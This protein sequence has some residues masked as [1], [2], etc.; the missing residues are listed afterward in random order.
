MSRATETEAA[1]A[2]IWL[3]QIPQTRE[4]LMLLTDAAEQLSQTGTINPELRAESISIAHK[5]AGS[6]GMFGFHSSSEHARL[7]QQDLESAGVPEAGQLCQHVKALRS[8]LQ[9]P[10][11]AV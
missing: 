2:A 1:I 9:K 4:R 5:L 8:S 3:R 11:S 10:L 6:L 7:V